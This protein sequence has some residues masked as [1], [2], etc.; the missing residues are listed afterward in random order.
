MNGLKVSKGQPSK[1]SLHPT[2]DEFQVGTPKNW[3]MKVDGQV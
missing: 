1:R 2:E 3:T